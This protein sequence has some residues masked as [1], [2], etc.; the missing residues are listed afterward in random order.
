MGIY[1]PLNI[2]LA[3]L[4]LVGVS[5]CRFVSYIIHDDDVV[6]KVGKHKLYRVEVESVIPAGTP[7]EDS[8]ALAAQY[9]RSWASDYIFDDAA[10]AGLSKKD[11]DLG[12]QLEQYRRSL[13]KYR[14]EQMFV[15]ERLDTVV[16]PIEVQAYYDE[17][18]DRFILSY[19]IVK[20]RYVR[21]SGDSPSFPEVR[22][23]I[24][25]DSD[26]DLAAMEEL[27]ATAA[28]RYTDFGGRWLDITELADEFGVDYGTLLALMSHS[29]IS[30]VAD[31]GMLEYAYVVDYIRAGAIPPVGY[32]ESRIKESIIAS[33]RQE[34]TERL[35]RDLLE[36]ARA[37][38]IYEIY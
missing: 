33:R 12:V 36:D 21:M 7:A 4:L 37:R 14:Y 5:S 25:S 19:P 32:C 3:A 17:H 9:I 29:T 11:L 30:Y 23:L 34:L 16:S 15:S 2:F 6:A 8:L 1:R 38:G 18:Q 22:K 26:E 28:E 27:A 31:D 24:S 13:V 35:E 20:A 10:A